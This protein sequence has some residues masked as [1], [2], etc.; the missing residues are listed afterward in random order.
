LVGPGNNGRDAWIAAQSLLLRGWEATLYLTPRHAVTEA[1]LSEFVEQ[2][3]RLVWHPEGSRLGVASALA[4]VSVAL[5]GL[6]GIGGKGA[7]RAPLAEVIEELNRC[8][9]EASGLTVVSV[10]GPSGLDA[11]QGVADGPAVLADATVVLGGAKRGLLLPD[12]ARY[13]G[14]LIF[15]EIGIVSE[16]V[17]APSVLDLPSVRGLLAP[18]PPDAHKGTFGRLLVIAGSE[19]YVGA[20]YLTCAAAARAGAGIVALAAPPWLRDVIASQLPE[21]TYVLLPDP[22]PA[23]DPVG[24]MEAILRQL[25]GFD[26]L[27]IG[28]GL[29]TDGGV[30][31]LVEQVL[32]QRA[33]RGIP[34]VVDA[35]ALNC[36]AQRPGWKD[37][38]GT[39]VVLTPHP[40]E[41]ARLAPESERDSTAWGQAEAAARAWSTTL[42]L[43]GGCTVVSGPGG[44]WVHPRP[45]PALAT[46]GTGDVLT[47]L[48]A[49]LLAQGIG[50]DEAARLSVWAHGEAAGRIGVLSRG[51][52]A[53]DL[54]REIPPALDLV[55]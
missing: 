9:A 34:A 36:L 42:I 2:G 40:G 48:V 3:G 23:G 21:V 14:Q 37:W 15:A 43:K 24:C 13:T 22:G 54:L 38:V 47:G 32:R 8:R 18:P 4:P 28:P 11:D 17:D 45:N 20:A 19:R 25:D 27:A 50:V 7:P 39:D 29:S 31:E 26:A 33:G 30:P 35:D 1:E 41:F 12:A 16:P 10:D 51:L 53:S 49:G 5:D 52:I 46:G 55:R 6:L 44:T